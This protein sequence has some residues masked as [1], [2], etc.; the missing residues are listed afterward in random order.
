MDE[1]GIKFAKMKDRETILHMVYLVKNSFPGFELEAYK[2]NLTK[3]IEKKEAIVA[4]QAQQLLGVVLFSK[5]KR[6]LEFIAVHPNYREKGVAKALVKKVIAQ[7]EKGAVITVV[8]FQKNDPQGVG[9]RHLYSSLGFKEGEE[10]EL[11]SYPCQV[12]TYFVE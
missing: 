11:F 7:F 3:A 10:L 12:F 2:E 1:M 4:T 8:T 5:E 9:A 6:E